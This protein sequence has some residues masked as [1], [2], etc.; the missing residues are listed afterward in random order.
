MERYSLISPTAEN[1]NCGYDDLVLGLPGCGIPQAST[2][3]A[4]PFKGLAK[5]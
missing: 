5:L 3:C 2:I 4:W 1:S